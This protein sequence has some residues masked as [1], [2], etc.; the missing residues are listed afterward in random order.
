MKRTAEMSRQRAFPWR[1]HRMISA[2]MAI[3][4][5]TALGVLGA[6]CGSDDVTAQSKAGATTAGDLSISEARIGEPAGPTAGLY[7]TV[8]NDGDGPATLSGISTEVSPEVQ[9]HETATDGDTTSMKRLTSGMEIPAGGTITLEPGGLHAMLMEVEPIEAGDEV[10]LTLSFDTSDVSL[11]APVVPLT[12][13]VG[14]M[15]DMGKD[16]GH[17]DSH[18]DG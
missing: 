7:F 3:A 18:G 17:D 1:S 4:A 8:T 5:L 10:G 12:E 11:R 9:L 2:V 14:G 15:D 6:A 16:G 13:I